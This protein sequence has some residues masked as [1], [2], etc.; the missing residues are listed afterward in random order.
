VLATLLLLSAAG[1]QA[2]STTTADGVLEIPVPEGWHADPVQ[3]GEILRLGGPS[4]FIAVRKP[5]KNR[6]LMVGRAAEM[7]Q[8]FSQKMGCKA[9][10]MQST[11]M[12]NGNEMTYHEIQC[13]EFKTPFYLGT[14]AMGDYVY[15]AR[16]H[17]E[18]GNPFKYGMGVYSLIRKAEEGPTPAGWVKTLE[19]DVMVPVPTGD[20]WED[21]TETQRGIDPTT[22]AH[23]TIGKNAVT[24]TREPS[25][26]DR[27]LAAMAS[28]EAEERTAA[29]GNCRRV[30]MGQ[31]KLP[32]GWPL[33]GL[34][35]ECQGPAG[36]NVYSFGAFAAKKA[37]YAVF[38]VY[39]KKALDAT[40]GAAALAGESKESDYKPVSIEV[41]T[42]HAP[43]YMIWVA[44]AAVPFVLCLLFLFRRKP[45]P[46]AEPDPPAE[47]P[48]E[49]PAEPP[50]A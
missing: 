46:S 31:L 11:S 12:P 21:Y 32:N 3:A 36:K 23:F 42:Y 19:G 13:P 35:M 34:A 24:L 17:V 20:G 43:P 29:L 14:F 25:Y 7:S 1:V 22:V 40:I 48:S 47:S 39:D 9:G 8:I 15:A 44:I 30:G 45:Q 37:G 26:D 38:G 28:S 49:P 27:G 41:P 4:G 50:A 10:G 6:G 16:W 33:M 5:E 2:A 18:V